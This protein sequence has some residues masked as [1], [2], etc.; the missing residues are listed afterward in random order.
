MFYPK[1]QFLN[2]KVKQSPSLVARKCFTMRPLDLQAHH[3]LKPA[4]KK[5]FSRPH[6]KII[7]EHFLSLYRSGELEYSH[8][9]HG[10]H[11]ETI[12]LSQ[13]DVQEIRSLALHVSGVK[14]V[15][16]PTHRV[17]VKTMVGYTPK[18]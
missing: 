9:L 18:C 4:S 5:L 10:V 2:Q 11:P 8:S 14:K 1:C 13:C 15:I 6:F 7:P 3:T 17:Y 12:D 16:L